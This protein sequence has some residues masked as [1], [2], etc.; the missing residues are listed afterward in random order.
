MQY[1]CAFAQESFLQKKEKESNDTK[2]SKWVMEALAA[3]M[4]V[5][6][7]PTLD[8]AFAI[9]DAHIVRIRLLRPP[10]YRAVEP[11]AGVVSRAKHHGRLFGIF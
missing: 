8:A 4:G 1:E 2:V 5:V 10:I 11:V 7:Q 3:L 9:V 6:M